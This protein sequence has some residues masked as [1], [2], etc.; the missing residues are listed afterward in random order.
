MYIYCKLILY[1]AYVFQVHLMGGGGA[2]LRGVAY[3][4]I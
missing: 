2:Y 4:L 3:Y 1:Q